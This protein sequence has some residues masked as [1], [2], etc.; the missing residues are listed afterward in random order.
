MTAKKTPKASTNETLEAKMDR[1]AAEFADELL[2]GNEV[3]K[4]KTDAFKVLCGYFYSTRKIKPPTDDDDTGG[5]F[6]GYRARLASATGRG[7]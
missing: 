4:H 7:K 3:P 6:D 5:S 2:K 1:L